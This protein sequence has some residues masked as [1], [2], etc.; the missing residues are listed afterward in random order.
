MLFE[1]TVCRAAHCDISLLPPWVGVLPVVLLVPV[2]SSSFPGPGAEWSRPTLH[3]D[4]LAL[5][6]VRDVPGGLPRPHQE[7]HTALRPVHLGGGVGM[8]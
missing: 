5:H 1:N 8:G 3:V 7:E 2:T 4:P 6:T